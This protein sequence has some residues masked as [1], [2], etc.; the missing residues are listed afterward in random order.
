MKTYLI[1]H[2]LG[3]TGDKATLFSEDGELIRSVTKSYP[4]DFFSG[5]SAEQDPG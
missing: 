5:N 3:T 2:D 4:T 1:A